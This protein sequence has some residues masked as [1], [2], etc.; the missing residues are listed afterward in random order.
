MRLHSSIAG[1]VLLASLT[2]C[3]STPKATRISAEAPLTVQTLAKACKPL[4]LKD[5]TAPEVG[6]VIG[7]I[8]ND[9]GGAFQ[10]YVKPN[11]V[12]FS[13]AEVFRDGTTRRAAGVWFTVAEHPSLP[14]TDFES[15]F[16]KLQQPAR[17]VPKGAASFIV[18]RPIEVDEACLCRLTAEVR[19]GTQGVS[20]G[21]VS[22]VTL[23]RAAR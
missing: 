6:R 12:T 9:L 4:C 2:G 5:A 19:P 16:G 22:K 18:D 8:T 10:L 7:K 1:F 21:T 3:R 13:E 17:D 11:D 15:W 20:G 23:R 14:V